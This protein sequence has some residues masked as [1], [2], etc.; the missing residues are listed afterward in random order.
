MSLMA[1]VDVKHHVYLLALF[2]TE[3]RSCERVEVAVLGSAAI[4]ILMVS[5][6]VKQRLQHEEWELRSCVKVEVAVLGSAAIIILMVPV[7]VKQRLQHEEWELRSCE[8]VEVAV[9]GSAAIIIL[10]VSVDVK[11]RRKALTRPPERSEEGRGRWSWGLIVN[12]T[13]LSFT[14]GFNSWSFRLCL[15]HCSAQ[16]LKEQVHKLFRIGGVSTLL[17]T[18]HLELTPTRP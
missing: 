4:I 16:L 14:S 12:W 15:C 13:C 17:W 3:L 11:Q 18:P 1:S 5:V 8:K 6:D 9:L 7:D 2:S 10:M